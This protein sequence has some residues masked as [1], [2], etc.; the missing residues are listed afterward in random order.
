MR[1]L[2]CLLPLKVILQSRSWHWRSFFHLQFV[3]TCF[4]LP[5]RDHFFQSFKI[6]VLLLDPSV[7]GNRVSFYLLKLL[8]S[9]P[10]RC[11]F[12]ID[13]IRSDMLKFLACVSL[14]IVT[15]LISVHNFTSVRLVMG[16]LEMSG[17]RVSD[18]VWVDLS[19]WRFY[20]S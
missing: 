6:L 1:L 7:S 20:L 8:I 19:V 2:S 16:W 10:S 17:K 5:S 14:N 9:Q 13:R 4:L 18:F 15:I 11:T 12:C 3:K